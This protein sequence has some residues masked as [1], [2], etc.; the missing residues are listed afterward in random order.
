VSVCDTSLHSKFVGD[1]D[2][3]EKQKT[4]FS[5]A[6]DEFGGATFPHPTNR[7][8]LWLAYME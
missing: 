6:A 2:E 5:S 7:W 1:N 3:H 8:A 4:I